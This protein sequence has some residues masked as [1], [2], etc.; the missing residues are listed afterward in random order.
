MGQVCHWAISQMAY[1]SVVLK[2][3]GCD[4]FHPCMF[5]PHMYAHFPHAYSEHIFTISVPLAWTN[6]PCKSSAD[7]HPSL[8][9]PIAGNRGCMVVHLSTPS[10]RFH[11]QPVPL[12]TPSHEPLGRPAPA[13]SSKVMSA[14]WS[15]FFMHVSNLSST[16]APTRRCPRLLTSHV[17]RLLHRSIA[18]VLTKTLISA[19]ARPYKWACGSRGYPMD[20]AYKRPQ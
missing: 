20:F 1:R 17:P 15:Q 18:P 8:T 7:L 5:V 4:S 2:P 12:V 10:S 9:R 3:N 16:S 19:Q 14:A 11:R 13:E 6:S